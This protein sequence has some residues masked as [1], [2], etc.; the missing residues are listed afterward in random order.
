[1]TTELIENEDRTLLFWRETGAGKEVSRAGWITVRI[2]NARA[3][4]LSFRLSKWTSTSN[5]W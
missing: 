2:Q 4:R 5:G 3:R 1:M